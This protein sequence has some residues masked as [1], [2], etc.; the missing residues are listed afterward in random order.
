M[1]LKPLTA[2]RYFVFLTAVA[3]LHLFTQLATAQ[4][5]YLKASPAG[6]NA[7]QMSLVSTVVV[8]LTQLVKW[9]GLPDK[10]GPLAVLGLAFLGVGLFGWSQ[11]AISRATTSITLL[12]P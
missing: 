6:M 1:Q 3:L 7:T 4:G 9:M 11:G 12:P 8:A 5:D 2:R 10:R